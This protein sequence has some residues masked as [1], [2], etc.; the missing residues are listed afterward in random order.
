ML[1]SL[2]SRITCLALLLSVAALSLGGMLLNTDRQLRG[3]NAWVNHT[4]EVIISLDSVPSHLREAE[5]GLRGYLLTGS[6]DYLGP[7]DDDLLQAKTL[8]ARVRTLVSDNPPQQRRAIILQ[9]LVASKSELMARSV[10][11]VRSEG[12]KRTVHPAARARGKA[13]MDQLTQLTATMRQTERDLL[14]ARTRDADERAARTRDLLLIGWPALALLI[15]GAAWIILRS[16]NRPIADLLEA[17]GRLSAGDREARVPVSGRTVEFQRLSRAYNDMADNLAT[18]IDR[19]AA[20]EQEIARTNAELSRR[21]QA[22]EARNGSIELIGEM[23]QRMQALRT[24]GEF[25]DV[26]Q[27]FLP[28][29]L[30]DNAG[31]LYVVNNSR[32]LLVRCL[33]WGDPLLSV[34]NFAPDACWGL[35][36]GQAHCVEKPGADVVCAH[37][38]GSLPIE[39]RCEPVL[40]GGEVLGLLYIE[41]TLN[42]EQVFRLGLLAEHI[43]L[44]LVNEHLRKRLREQSI[45]DPLTNLFNRRYMEEA[46]ALETARASRS[47]SPISV[48]MADVDHFKRFND[49]FGHEAGDALLKTVASTI[50]EHFRDGD[51]V[52]RYGGEEFTVIAPGASLELICRRAEILRQSVSRLAVHYRGTRLGPVTISL[53]I[54]SWD[55]NSGG[56]IEDL[57]AE[58]DRALFRAKR[59]GRNRIELGSIVPGQLAAE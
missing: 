50:Q 25:A 6:L 5:S 59:L 11:L 24:D 49:E 43:A 21:G 10:A 16:V 8:A 23:G 45:R 51:I 46:L 55:G 28:K 42:A 15:V 13:I 57:V 44:A 30:P 36:R 3:A 29:V 27:C 37:T 19:H 54:E 1:T 41:G 18:A 33:E 9:S 48:I 4:Q 47:G 22:L 2:R 35:R 39:R 53:G 20:A 26:L 56:S 52:C 12:L 34:E 40:A 31:A 7:F 14:D 38:S 17:V 32:N 58:A